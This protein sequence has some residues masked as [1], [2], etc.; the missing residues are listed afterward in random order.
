MVAG[1]V[2]TAAYGGRFVIVVEDDVDIT[3][4][5]DVLWAM[6]TRCDPERDIA[7]I[8]RAWSGPLDPAVD[9]DARPY[10]S[11]LVID[12]TRPFEWRDKFPEPVWTA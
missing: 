11:R 6:M 1:Q 3:D 8:K 9:P 12:A 10:N 2:G 7:V 5:D 4:I